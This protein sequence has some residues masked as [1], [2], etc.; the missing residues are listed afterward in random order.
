MRAVALCIVFLLL[1]RLAS[2]AQSTAV[3]FNRADCDGNQHHLF[4]ELDSGSV[5]IMEFIMTCNSCI[6]A[7][8]SL[9]AMIADIEMQYPGRIRFYQLAYTN[10]YSCATMNNFKNTNSF[11]SAVFDSAA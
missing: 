2:F 1:S 9:E 6:V 7:G 5:V 3:D 4:S 8:N 11:N 10:S